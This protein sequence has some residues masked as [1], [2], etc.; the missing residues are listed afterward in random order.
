VVGIV[1]L[2][3]GLPDSSVSVREMHERS[4]RP[5]A[6]ILAWTHCSEIPVFGAD[7]PAWQLISTVAGT[8]LERAGVSP[9]EVG[10]VIVAGSGDWDHPAWSPAA[11]VAAQI[12]VTGAHCFEVI[13]FCNAAATA[14]QIAADAIAVGRVRYSLVLL[15]ERTSGTVDYV[16]PDS[17]E[18]FN[19]GDCAVAVL[20]GDENVSFDLL[21]SR[22]R[23][24]PRLCDDYV[25][26]HED[27]R[28]VTRRRGR[29]L[30]LPLTYLKNYETLTT[31]TLSELGIGI[32]D[33][34]YL[35]VNQVDR[36]IHERLLAKLGL[37]FERSVFNYSRFG[38]MGSGDTFI[39]L[40]ELRSRQQLRHEDVVLL[41]T[42]GTG[43]SWGVTALRYQQ[44]RTGSGPLSGMYP[45]KAGRLT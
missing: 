24:D 17:V 5:E 20:L 35:L 30:N 14:I 45:T 21:G 8:V 10:Q 32:D 27:G 34:R 37:P 28:V 16:D 4:G 38:H 9:Q 40:A 19:T 18:M 29:R 7:Q 15:G 26:E 25:G 31:Q 44:Q 6:D 33:V 2:E 12:G 22:T 42:S 23:T 41:A 1:D 36:R 3:F 43:F 11:K 39:A 13:N